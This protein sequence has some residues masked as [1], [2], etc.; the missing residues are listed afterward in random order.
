MSPPWPA[1]RPAAGTLG[2]GTDSSRTRVV[3]QDGRDRLLRLPS[4]ALPRPVPPPSAS[5]RVRLSPSQRSPHTERRRRTR[6]AECE[7]EWRSGGAVAWTR[8]VTTVS[9][10]P[11]PAPCARIE[12]AG[13][14]PTRSRR[15]T[16]TRSPCGARDSDGPDDSDRRCF[17]PYL[18]ISLSLSLSPPSQASPPIGPALLGARH[19]PAMKQV[20]SSKCVRCGA[21]FRA[22]NLFSITGVNANTP[23]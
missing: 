12:P 8:A 7:L 19:C 10:S 13:P 6:R 3:C 16:V 21:G 18:W 17:K 15:R 11:A 20:T 14:G 23:V 1:C 2:G 5:L 22:V 4:E 9:R